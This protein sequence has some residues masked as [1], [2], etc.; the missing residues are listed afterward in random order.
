M[1]NTLLRLLDNLIRIGLFILA[2]G[3]VVIFLIAID[4]FVLQQRLYFLRTG[5]WE[6]LVTISLF[7]VLI[8]F[9]LKRLLVIQYKW[10]LK[11]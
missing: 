5:N 4:T 10:G 3:L 9:T 7:G 8:A 11:K 6:D 1:K 2:F